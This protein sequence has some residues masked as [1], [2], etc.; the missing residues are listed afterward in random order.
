LHLTHG[1]AC[2]NPLLDVCVGHRDDDVLQAAVSV[3]QRHGDRHIE[4]RGAVLV[5]LDQN[6]ARLN[7]R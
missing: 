1:A 7:G 2:R 5:E 3:L 6:L 4:D